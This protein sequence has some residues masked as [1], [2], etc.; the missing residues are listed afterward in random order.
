[1]PEL[2]DLPFRGI[3]AYAARCAM[4]VRPLSALG[5]QEAVD[6]AIAVA[7]AFCRG[8]A[9]AAAEAATFAEAADSVAA[10]EAAFA[11]AAEDEGAGA[12]RAAAFA[13]FAAADAF[14]DAAAA[15]AVARAGAR[16]AARAAAFAGAADARAADADLGALIGLMLGQPGEIGD[17]I[18]PTENGPLGALWPQGEPPWFSAWKQRS[19]SG[20]HRRLKQHGGALFRR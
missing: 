9:F 4:R 12:A 5:Q 10:E 18:D 1:M 20:R 8:D 11:G 15:F 2:K 6:D 3:V 14:T 19:L 16:A 7:V 17:A 13:A